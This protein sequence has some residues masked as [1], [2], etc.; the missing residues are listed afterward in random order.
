MALAVAATLYE[1]RKW[2]QV[3]RAISV[4]GA[5]CAGFAV[6]QAAGFHV[7]RQAN[8]WGLTAIGVVLLFGAILLMIMPW[9]YE[10][11]SA[12]SNAT[13][14]GLRWPADNWEGGP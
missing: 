1:G 12:L 13:T 9:E 5:T 3:P 4:I 7:G 14:R 10:R 11:N 8:E 6:G 2:K